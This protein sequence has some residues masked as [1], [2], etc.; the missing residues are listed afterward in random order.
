MAYGQ[1]KAKFSTMEYD[2]GIIPYNRPAEALIT[3]KNTGNKP[4]VVNKISSSCGCAVVKWKGDV[5]KPGEVGEIKVVYDAKLMG[6]FFREISVYCNAEPY[7]YN[8][9]LV[10]EVSNTKMDYTKTHAYRIGDILIDTNELL[11]D[12]IKLGETYERSISVVNLGDEPYKPN[13]ILLP[14]YLSFKCEP[15]VL[16]KNEQG[17]IKVKIDGKKLRTVGLTET[18]IYLA[19]FEGDEICDDTNISVSAFVLP[20]VSKLTPEQLKNAPVFNIS[21]TEW[22]V[23]KSKRKRRHTRTFE[24]TN[25]GKSVLNIERIQISGDAVSVGLSSKSIEPGEKTKLK[26]T[27]Q[28]KHSKRHHTRRIYIITNDPNKLKEVITVKL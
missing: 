3:L 18:S 25:T 11:F 6:H 4:L 13:L 12:D 1:A 17:F 24:I 9:A 28:S 14:P 22:V 16:R 19:R 8:I 10:G 26:V 15:E 20:S 2:Y 27:V 7:M 5:L 23:D 21:S